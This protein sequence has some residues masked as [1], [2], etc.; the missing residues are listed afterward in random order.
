MRILRKNGK[1]RFCGWKR[2]QILNLTSSREA[3][4]MG[5]TNS[6]MESNHIGW[7]ECKILN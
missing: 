1:I 6:E 5:F 2:D 3:G 4:M 7:S